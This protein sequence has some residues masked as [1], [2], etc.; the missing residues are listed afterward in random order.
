MGQQAAAPFL[1]GLAFFTP[2]FNN[3]NWIRDRNAA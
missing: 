1:S 3:H 2:R